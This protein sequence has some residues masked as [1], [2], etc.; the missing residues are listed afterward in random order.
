[1]CITLTIFA[2]I[3]QSAFNFL[4]KLREENYWQPKC[5]KNDIETNGINLMLIC[6]QE[7]K[8]NVKEE[9]QELERQ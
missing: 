8:N 6:A 7:I 2:S 3:L 9:L 4:R 5:L 1:M